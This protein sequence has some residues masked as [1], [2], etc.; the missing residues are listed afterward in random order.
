MP[1]TIKPSPKPP[2]LQACKQ[3]A[4][5]CKT[6]QHTATYCN[7]LQHTAKYCKILQNT[8][9]HCNIQYT[10]H[11]QYTRRIHTTHCTHHNILRQKI[12]LP[13][14]IFPDC[15]SHLM[16]GYMQMYLDLF[17]R[18]RHQFYCSAFSLPFSRGERDFL[19]F[20]RPLKILILH[21]YYVLC[22]IHPL[23]L[24]TFIL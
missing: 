1:N 14:Y 19:F 7:I 20:R 13:P 16:H 8:A 4:S 24:F 10:H 12:L 2:F 15:K 23:S 18:A 21:A 17:A 22:S 9:I 11:T 5:H 3:T 6:L